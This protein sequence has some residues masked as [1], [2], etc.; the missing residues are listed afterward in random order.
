M[1][2]TLYFPVIRLKESECYALNAVAATTRSSVRPVFEFFRDDPRDARDVDAV[3]EKAWGQ[4]CRRLRESVRSFD[5]TFLDVQAHED[6]NFRCGKIDVWSDLRR[7][8][9]TE[10]RGLVPVS[11]LHWSAAQLA[12]VRQCAEE[13]THGHALRL[14]RIDLSNPENLLKRTGEWLNALTT[15]PEATALFV[16]LGDQPEYLTFRK[17]GELLPFPERWKSCT[18]LCGSFPE[19]LSGPRDSQ[20]FEYSRT[21]WTSWYDQ[22]TDPNAAWRP[23]FGDYLMFSPNARENA[24][25]AGTISLR[26]TWDKIFVIFKGKRSKDSPLKNKQFCGHAMLLV[27]DPCFFGPHFSSGDSFLAGGIPQS[28]RTLDTSA[29]RAATINHH[30]EATVAQLIS[31]DGTTDL[32]RKR[33][34]HRRGTVLSLIPPSSVQ[35][36]RRSA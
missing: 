36:D 14:T 23:C 18:V 34:A 16:D 22:A 30:I 15:T 12:S 5:T 4:Q 2:P 21:E 26:Y 7:R 13:W 3:R 9:R 29:W 33:A 25:H 20:R 6:T 19:E 27:A 28:V 35:R 8:L 11:Y 10:A 31:A 32:A 24:G 1:R 17:L